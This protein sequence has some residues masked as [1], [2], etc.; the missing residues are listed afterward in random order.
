MDII[1]V[2]VGFVLAGLFVGLFGWGVRELK[3]Y[4]DL[5]PGGQVYMSLMLFEEK[6]AQWI[7]AQAEKYGEDLSIDSIRHKWAREAVGWIAPKIPKLM[8]AFDY[9]KADL[10]DDIAL[11]VQRQ[12]DKVVHGGGQDLPDQE[13][14]EKGL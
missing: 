1:V 7:I 9:S 3:K 5:D 2:I 4:L 10:A 13:Q 6:G 8:D 12:L 14:T 11:I